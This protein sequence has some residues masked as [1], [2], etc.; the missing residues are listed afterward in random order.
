MNRRS[1][2]VFTVVALLTFTLGW[3]LSSYAQSGTPEIKPSGISGFQWVNGSSFKLNSEL[4]YGS[5]NRTDVVQFPEQ[6][7]KYLIFNKSGA[8]F[9]K[10][11]S[12]GQIR[13][14]SS[15]AVK[16][17][18][19][20]LDNLTSG[21]T[22]KETVVLKGTFII[23][24]KIL[25][26]SYTILDLSEAK[27]IQ[28]NNT[29]IDGGLIENKDPTS[30]NI[31]I[32]IKN[33]VLNVN[34]AFNSQSNG[35]LITNSSEVRVLYVKIIDAP[36]RGIRFITTRNSEVSGCVITD[37]GWHGISL[38][39]SSNNNTVYNNIIKG[40]GRNGIFVTYSNDNAVF[41]NK[42]SN[43]G[44]TSYGGIY[45]HY[46]EYCTVENNHIENYTDY[47]I[48][49]GD[50]HYSKIYGNQVKYSNSQGIFI[51]N[52]KH[53]S[54]E[55]NTVYKNGG[56]GILVNKDEGSIIGENIV[57]ENDL[58]GIHI[59]ATAGVGNFTIITSNSVISNSQSS[60][61]TYDGIKITD[62]TDVIITSNKCYND[63]SI[64]V[65]QRRG[66]DSSGASDYLIVVANNCRN[67][68]FSNSINLVGVNNVEANNIES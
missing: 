28:A 42:I 12:T 6:V 35:I 54:V 62:A 46:G 18:N 14:T 38:E 19:W 37:S 55:L 17:I 32:I 59:S 27:I 34:K 36:R 63:P 49:T 43:G 68:Y 23:T 67:N 13:E 52:T 53:A 40:S 20:A 65:G 7:A 41:G 3:T 26:P 5:N 66:I 51:D 4:W 2:A 25:L 61:S 45:I 16:V 11:L 10:D 39:T 8:I 24:Q 1:V 31:E 44:A 60:N 48:I 30:G 64:S 58:H 21:R 22:W 57:R 15:D 47:G 9:W 50:G 56:N 29:N 33:G